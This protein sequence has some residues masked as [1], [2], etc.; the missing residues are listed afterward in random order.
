MVEIARV[1]HTW[2]AAG[3]VASLGNEIALVYLENAKGW[4]IV[5]GNIEPGESPLDTVRREAYEEGGIILEDGVR[6]I[7]SFRDAHG[8]NLVFEGDIHEIKAIPAGFETT[9]MCLYSPDEA[10]ELS[11]QYMPVNRPI[12]LAALES[13][14]SR[15]LE[16]N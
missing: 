6:P 12:I 8:D 16:N 14:R 10:I 13:R 2:N 11:A 3:T 4:D 5:F 9:H 15:H 1:Q 7:Y